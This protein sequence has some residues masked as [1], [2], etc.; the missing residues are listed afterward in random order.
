MD[1]IQN[2]NTYLQHE[3]KIK[4]KKYKNLTNQFKGLVLFRSKTVSELI[5]FCSADKVYSSGFGGVGGGGVGGHGGGVGGGGWG[6]GSE[7]TGR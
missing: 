4:H 5:S 3:E 1:S 2:V 6:R 7:L